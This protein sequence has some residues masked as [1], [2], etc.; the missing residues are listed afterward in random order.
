MPDTPPPPPS[1]PAVAHCGHCGMPAGV[2]TITRDITQKQRVKFGV[3]WVL[4]SF[5]TLGGALALWLIMPRK[6]VVI[7]VDRQ[8]VCAACGAPA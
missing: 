8:H 1:G 5:F 3:F 4:A 7:S 2:K 6:N